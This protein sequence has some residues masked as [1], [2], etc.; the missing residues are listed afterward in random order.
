MAPCF[1]IL[2]GLA[3]SLKSRFA[4]RPQKSLSIVIESNAN[5]FLKVLA[6]VGIVL[7]H[8]TKIS[9]KEIYWN[10]YQ[11]SQPGDIKN[12][13]PTPQR[14][15]APSPTARSAGATQLGGPPEHLVL[16]RG[17]RI[18]FRRF[19]QEQKDYFLPGILEWILL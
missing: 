6:Q 18:D 19:Q 4:P 14:R 16:Y 11:G 17:L 8:A 7:Y 13:S 12:L 9:S 15:V 5:N 2:Y 1:V 10:L 3:L